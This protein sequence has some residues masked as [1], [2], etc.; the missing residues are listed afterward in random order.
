MK[1]EKK[2]LFVFL[3]KLAELL[4]MCFNCFLLCKGGLA[5]GN[6]CRRLG[7]LE[8]CLRGP[9]HP[10]REFHIVWLSRNRFRELLREVCRGSTGCSVLS[11][12][13]SKMGFWRV[14]GERKVEK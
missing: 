2:H 14:D 8:E 6:D 12:R 3:S 1:S 4:C 7:R 11:T 13:C 9:Y 10:S 5:K